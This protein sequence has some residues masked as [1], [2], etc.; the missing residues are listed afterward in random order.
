MS[1]TDNMSD[2]FSKKEL[3]NGL[4]LPNKPFTIPMP[5]T[6]PPKEEVTK[7]PIPHNDPPKT[8]RDLVMIHTE[9]TKKL[10]S[11]QEAILK[12]NGSRSEDWLEHACKDERYSVKVLVTQYISIRD[13][14]LNFLGSKL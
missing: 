9:Y 3:D 6:P 5:D 13:E 14:Y 4:G 8:Y 11:I 7:I 12:L 1:I 2:F 10:S